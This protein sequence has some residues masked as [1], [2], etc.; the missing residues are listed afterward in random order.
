MH[1]DGLVTGDRWVTRQFALIAVT[2]TPIYFSQSEKDIVS[3]LSHS[4]DLI[5]TSN[6]D[7]GRRIAAQLYAFLAGALSTEYGRP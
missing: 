7:K 3:F 4:A 2:I 6:N 5:S 1:L